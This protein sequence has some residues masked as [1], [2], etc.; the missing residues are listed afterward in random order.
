VWR[1]PSKCEA[2][3]SIPRTA[4]GEGRGGEG[5]G[6]RRKGREEGKE[7]E[8]KE[9]RAKER[10]R[11]RKERKR[12]EG[13]EER[14]RKEGR[15]ERRKEGRKAHLIQWKPQ[16]L[17]SFCSVIQDFHPLGYLMVQNDCKSLPPIQ[18]FLLGMEAHTCNPGTREAEAKESKV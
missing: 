5:K 6:R 12:E 11:E 10:K 4:R 13:K 18:E 2:L 7:S 17:L 3:S 8:E 14:G 16:M 9:R 15:K 1:L